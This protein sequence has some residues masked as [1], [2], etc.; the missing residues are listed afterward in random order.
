LSRRLLAGNDISYGL[1]L[2]HMPLLNAYIAAGAVRSFGGGTLVF[3]VS[4]CVAVLS[5]RLVEKPALALKG[6]NGSPERQV[7]G[8]DANTSLHDSR[9]VPREPGTGS[10]DVGNA[11]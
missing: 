3:A 1:Y 10:V 9:G 7:T 8:T 4:V 11:D 6:A 2:Y 5:W